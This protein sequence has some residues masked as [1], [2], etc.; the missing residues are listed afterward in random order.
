MDPKLIYVL[1]AIGGFL[2][3]VRGVD[4]AHLPEQ[5]LGQV[6]PLLEQVGSS[7]PLTIT[8]LIARGRALQG[9]PNAGNLDMFLE[10]VI[11]TCIFN[12][13]S[14]MVCIVGIYFDSVCRK[15]LSKM[16]Y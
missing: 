8:Y 4:G 2:A 7:G 13:I 15:T 12:F 1:R 5:M 3:I 9:S 10:H 11:P 14:L 6:G 16:L